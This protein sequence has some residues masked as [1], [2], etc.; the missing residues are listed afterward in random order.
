MIRKI[1]LLLSVGI[2]AI[3][4]YIL[5]TRPVDRPGPV[6]ETAQGPVQ[7]VVSANDVHNIKA[8]PFAAPPVGDLRWRPPAAAQNW[9]EVRDA[10]VFGDQCMQLSGDGGGFLNLMIERHGLS[11]FKK[12][13]IRQAVS[14]S[15]SSAMS[16]ES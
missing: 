14:A 11:S 3:A 1:L 7:G 2:T 9:T 13:L 10:S 4:I 6:I 15:G 12:W 5:A 8:I 16:E